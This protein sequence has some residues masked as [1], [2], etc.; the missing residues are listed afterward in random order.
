M[1]IFHLE[2]CGIHTLNSSSYTAWSAVTK[3]FYMVWRRRK[4]FSQ[5]RFCVERIGAVHV[6]QC[7]Q[8]WVIIAVSNVSLW[9]VDTTAD[10]TVFLSFKSTSVKLAMWQ[11]NM[12]YGCDY[13]Q[14]QSVFYIYIFHA[15][16]FLCV[17]VWDAFLLWGRSGGEKTDIFLYLHLYFLNTWRN[18][19]QHTFCSVHQYKKNTFIFYVPAT[20]V[21]LFVF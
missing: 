18:W 5:L 4:L 17:C 21:F 15:Y 20:K 19:L 10:A 8:W 3:K 6:E 2:N 14:Y 9:F 1:N 12:L 11:C 7:T 13:S 16:F